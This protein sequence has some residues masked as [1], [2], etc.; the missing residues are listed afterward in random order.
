MPWPFASL[1]AVEQK[2]PS[3]DISGVQP[4]SSAWQFLDIMP[5]EEVG[6][7]IASEISF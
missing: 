3:S 6:F 7:A 2:E 5:L 4:K 1:A